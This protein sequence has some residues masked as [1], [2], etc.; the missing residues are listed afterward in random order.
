MKLEIRT[1]AGGLFAMPRLLKNDEAAMPEGAHTLMIRE[2]LHNPDA[3]REGGR[4]LK[5]FDLTGTLLDEKGATYMTV[6]LAVNP[7][8]P[9]NPDPNDLMTEYHTLQFDF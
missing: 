3:R 7:S 6:V 9:V 2:A 5:S 8:T 4:L 1:S